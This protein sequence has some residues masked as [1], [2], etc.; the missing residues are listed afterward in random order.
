LPENNNLG[1]AW[2]IEELMLRLRAPSDDLIR[3]FL[4]QQ[5]KLK[6]SY[7]SVGDSA[8]TPPADFVVDSTRIKLGEGE[9]V[10]RAAVEGLKN[11]DQFKLGWVKVQPSCVPIQVGES[12]AVVARSIGLVWINACQIIYVVDESSGPVSRFG[13]AYGTLPDHAAIGEER[14]LIEWNHDDDSVWFD[15]LAFSKPRHFLVRLGYPIV[16]LTQK[17]FGRES[18]NAMLKSVM[19]LTNS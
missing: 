6:F 3:D 1:T 18:T 10:Y 9:K 12:V 13:F 19:N 8:H 7:D 17:R 14:F 15:I 16:R 11:W 2:K 4:T 5:G